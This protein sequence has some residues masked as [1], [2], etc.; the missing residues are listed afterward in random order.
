LNRDRFKVQINW[1]AED[2]TI[3]NGQA[4]LYSSDDS[5]MFWFFN[6]D[7]WEMLV[8]VL[9]GCGSNDRFWVFFAATTDLAFTLTVTDTEAG[10]SKQYFNSLKHPADAVTDT[11][12]FN[13]CSIG[14]SSGNPSSLTDTRQLLDYGSDKQ[15]SSNGNETVY[16]LGPAREDS[17][18]SFPEN[19]SCTPTETQLCL[20][21]SRFKVQ[22][23][24]ES[25][26]G[27]S[28]QGYAVPYGSEDSG[29]FWFFDEDNWEMLI[30]VLDGCA[31]NDR[32]WVF[33]AATTDQK[34]VVTVTD[35]LTE[36]VLQYTNPMKHPANAVTDTSAFATCP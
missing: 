20:N 5:G 24:W 7:N 36:E 18:L 13:T 15:L 19:D 6:E 21:N 9:D 16:R 17:L 14:N 26:D 2:G 10:I 35:T 33:F 29:M 11:D 34:F 31:F 8:K 4:V 1:L 28:G 23:N 12:A 25:Q 22:V 3:G 32:Y 27:R 30:K